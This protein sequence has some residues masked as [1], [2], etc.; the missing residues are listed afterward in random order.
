[1]SGMDTEEHY[2]LDQVALVTGAGRGIGKSVSSSLAARGARVVLAARTSGEIEALAGEIREVGGSALA[3]PTD[4]SRE[5]EVGSLFERAIREW[6][7]LDIL[8]NNAGIGLFG[9][10]DEFPASDWDR[11]METNLR[12]TFL[13]SRQALRIMKPQRTGFIINIASVVGFKGYPDQGAYAASKHGI[14]G[15]TKSM[16]VEA[17]PHGI[18]VSAVLPGGVNT[19]LIGDARP[20][21]DHSTLLWPEDI[22]KTVLYLLSLPERAAVDQIY[23]RRSKSAPF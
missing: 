8:V 18:R 10:I 19:D 9:P 16:A 20:D 2:L 14:M 13:C 4:V 15:L 3:V 5:D 17:Q 11:V 23:I 21:L 12:G 6:G 7:R 22:A 1:M